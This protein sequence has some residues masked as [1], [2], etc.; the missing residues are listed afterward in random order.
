[1]Q[2]QFETGFSVTARNLIALIAALVLAVVFFVVPWTSLDSTGTTTA[3][4]LQL[5][6]EH[7]PGFLEVLATSLPLVAAVLGLAGVVAGYFFPQR[8]EQ[9][10]RVSALGG[11]IGLAY[12][13][14]FFA[15]GGADL[16]E[17]GATQAGFWVALI[18]AFVL[19][20][21]PVASLPIALL[22]PSLVVLVLFLYYPA[23]Q[24]FVLSAFR[25]SRRIGAPPIYVGLGN[26]TSLA[27]EQA[28]IASIG[29]TVF[30]S[31]A[32]IVIGLA[33]S[34]AIATLAMQNVRGSTIYR[35]L[36][37]WPYAL[38]PA[39]AGAI[40]LV[41][42]NEQA[43][44]FRYITD[45][46]FGIQP[47][48]LSGPNLAP[49]VVIL[50]SVWK[51]LGYNIL[52]YMAGL[53]NVP[54]EALEAASIDGANRWQRFWRITFPLLSPMTF[55]LLFTNLIFSFFGIFGLIDILT[56]GG[57]VGSTSVL[58]YK[59]Y[60]DAFNFRKFGPAAAQSVVLFAIVIG[61]TILQFRLGGRRVH[62][63]A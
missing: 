32:I 19:A 14:T 1:M 25:K 57:P 48:W 44:L 41:L 5:L 3:T 16:V 22:I 59:L 45:T 7:A 26:Y 63:G 42:F 35:T 24:T 40:F 29:T 12:F 28:Y 56:Q 37:I 11:I 27:S 50:A 23:A 51:N 46:L 8:R 10:I 6:T 18:V 61:I 39:I 33:L 4:G 54:G 49:W 15:H 30:I 17:L 58:I 34:L 38:S 2:A 52:F 20:T 47:R 62:Y 36:L 13:I 55:F 21:F 60:E 31:L 9:L 53:Q 43:G